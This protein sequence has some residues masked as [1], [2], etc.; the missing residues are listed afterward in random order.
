VLNSLG[1]VVAINV[2]VN[3][4]GYRSTPTVTFIG[5]N[6]SGAVAYPRMTNDVIRQF[7]TVI[8]YDRFQYQT[9]IQTWSSEGTYENGTL[10]RYNDRVWSALNADGSS[11][12]VGPTFDLENWV[13]VD[14]ATYTYPGSTQAT[15]LT[16]VDRTMGL[17]VPG[18]NEYGLE[19]PLLVDGVDYPG[20]QVYGDYFTGTQTLDANY[21][22]EFADIYL[23]ERFS[24]INVDGGEFVGLYEG[25]APEEL[26]NGAEYDTLDMRIYTRPGSDWA[27]NGHGFQ[28]GTR[29]YTFE[30]GITYD[31]S[32]A[33]IVQHTFQI[34]VSN[35]ATGRV[36][37]NNI[38]YVVNWDEQTITILNNVDAFDIISID[39]YEIGGG[40]QLFRGNY[41]G[42]ELVAA[43][44]IVIL[45]VGY[46]QLVEV[47]VFVNGELVAIPETTPYTESQVWNQNNTYDP[48]SVVFN[49]NEITV[50]NTTAVYNIVT[51]NSTSALTVGQPIVFGGTV[52]GGIVAGQE[53]YVQNIAN[54]TQF[55][56]TDTAGSLT[57]LTL[58]TATGVMSGSP[59]G[60][61]YRSIQTVPA[62]ILLTNLDYWLP[63]IPTIRTKCVITATVTAADAVSI[64]VLGDAVS[65]TVADT[66]AQ[67]NAIILLGSL[68]SLSVGQT[69]TFSGYSLGGVLTNTSYQIFSIVDN[70]INAIT[71]TEDG[72]TEVEL[73][74]NTAIWA[75]QL[76]AKFTLVD[77]QSWSTPVTEQF[78]VD[79]TII[80]NSA[81]TL[82]SPPFGTNP[83]NMIVIVNGLRILGPSGIEWIGDG[84]T[85][86]FGLPQRLGSSFSQ[87]SINAP[88]DIL[89][90]VNGVLQKQSFGAQGGTYSVTNWDGSNTPGRQVLFDTVP[91]SGAVILIAITTLSLSNF[92][93]DPSGPSFTEELQISATLNL[94]DIINVITW[95]DTTQQN[96]LTLTFAGPIDT[97]VTVYQEYDTTDYDSPTFND[98]TQPLPGEFA[99]EVGTSVPINDFDLLR[100]SVDA[101]RLWV[102]LDGYRLFEGTDYT[103]SGQYLILAQGAISPNQIL[104]VT[105]FTNSIVPE[106]AAFRIFQ[107]MRG[108]QATY[109][110][111]DSTTTQLSQTLSNTADIIYV[112]NAAS[113]SQPDLTAGIFGVI[114]VDGERIMYRY[115]DTALNTVS[116]LQR[117][118]AGTAAATHSI[119]ANVYDIGRGNLLNQNYQDYVVKDSGMGDGTTTVFYA[120]SIDI[121][122]FGDSS[123]VYVESI[124]VYVGGIQQYN[125]SNTTANSQ[126]RWIVSLFDPLAVEFIVDGDYSA[127][128]SGSEVTILQRRGVTWYAAGVGT[129]SDGIALQETDTIAA[130]FL[131][132]R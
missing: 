93:Y 107:D 28:I 65:I 10:V 25:H 45:P 80:S 94:G 114:T 46:S 35:I 115:R 117:G 23:G 124:E 123:T 92:A 20:V 81:V 70:S 21:Q 89:V 125:Y 91:A 120:P 95:N 77:Y 29:R 88:T 79:Q 60:T 1:E 122:D 44:N 11:A 76:T 6:G 27:N 67:G 42:V 82:S 73:I 7:R 131:C 64:L 47:Y 87:A 36:L 84:T 56:I 41:T 105:E 38:D 15:G 75:G 48:I 3:G 37:N 18:A 97:G 57:P 51:C 34:I 50:T 63:F 108:V 99:F 2:T 14:A 55:Y 22:S 90:W 59:K 68:D 126:Y 32:W 130:R 128:A 4:A 5:G 113:L 109:R 86:S 43:D 112:E 71:I 72:V 111:T 98:P 24:D 118:T 30:P 19:L 101:S 103:I 53:Y 49:N 78:I 74:D 8:R 40:S 66:Q 83:A 33:G 9:A 61:Y 132:D 12:V 106:A 54:G 100:I 16:G 17:Y 116:G 26:V 58:T 96:A 110:I 121:A 39:V 104:I 119:G 102:T 127:P 85:A 13:L 69:V 52:F 62:G 129:P 31:Y